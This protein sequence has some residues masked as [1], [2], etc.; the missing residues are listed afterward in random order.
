MERKNI[1]VDD[2]IAVFKRYWR[3]IM[4]VTILAGGGMGLKEVLAPV[5]YRGTTT[6]LVITPS[7]SGAASQLAVLNA[8][9]A[10]PL[11]TIKGVMTSDRE[12]R[13]IIEKF[14]L[15]WRKFE[16]DFQVTDESQT[17]QLMVSYDSTDAKLIL[18]LLQFS[19]DNLA[20]L[21][22]EF[23]FSIG[24]KQAD[25]MKK[26]VDKK[27]KEVIAAEEALL[28]FQ[29]TLKT[30]S[31]PT[32]PK[33][34]SIYL[35][36]L[37]RLEV[38][39][40][41]VKEQLKIVRAQLASATSDLKVPSAIPPVLAWQKKLSDIEYKLRVARTTFAE[42]H[43]EVVRLKRVEKETQ[44]QFQSDVKKY[45]SSVNKNVDPTIAT[46]E[47]KRMLLE[48]QVSQA[49]KLAKV[50]PEE[51]LQ[52]ARY[53]TEVLTLRKV[54]TT[55]RGQYEQAKLEAEISKVRWNVLDPPYIERKPVNKRY[56]VPVLT[57]AVA[58]FTLSM[59]IGFVRFRKSQKQ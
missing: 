26:E 45:M 14:D 29:K 54:S 24:T 44:E 10:T 8:S 17:N 20:A 52:L 37:Q 13:A 47:A 15:D 2:L 49:R 11:R 25:A 59:I 35:E 18:K 32:D 7:L 12:T 36:T 1:T 34:V 39:L 57:G 42:E 31:D 41:G 21:D 27:E 23:N 51:G 33:S 19:V 28:K 56:R 50:A 53:V 5:K 48:Y 4:A 43:P 38:E 3:S 46:L 30:I 22:R 16:Y 6:I 58:A 55:L 9:A 40:G